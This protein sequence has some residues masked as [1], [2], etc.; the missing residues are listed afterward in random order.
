MT[1]QFA[2]TTDGKCGI[3]NGI[4][5]NLKCKPTECCSGMG[6]CGTSSDYCSTSFAGAPQTVYNGEMIVQNP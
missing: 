6:W 4:Q 3:N 1:P 5:T 2:V